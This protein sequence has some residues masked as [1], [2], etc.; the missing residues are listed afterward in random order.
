MKED[1]DQPVGRPVDAQQSAGEP[2]GDPRWTPTPNEEPANGPGAVAALVLILAAVGILFVVR[3]GA[4][5]PIAFIVAIIGMVM[6]HEWGHFFTARRAGMKATE[7]F[8]GFGPRIWSFR[9]GETEYGVKAV[10]IGGYVR[11]IGM[12]NLEQ[13]DPAEEDR[14]FRSKRFGARFTV[15]VAGVTMNLICAFVL[16][17]IAFAATGRLGDTTTTVSTVGRDTPAEAAGI[18]AG[19]RIVSVNG[20]PLDEW[21]DIGVALTGTIDEQIPLVVERDGAMRELTATPVA[22]GDDSDVG[23]LGVSPESETLDMSPGEAVGETAS[24]MW[25]APVEVGKEIGSFMSPSRLSEEFGAI[26][27]D[28]QR[29]GACVSGIPNRPMGILGMT[30]ASGDIAGGSLWNFVF[31]LAL[32]N[33]I[34]AVF[35][36]IPL[37]PFD[38]GHAAIAI[39]ETINGKITGRPNYRS[40][41]RKMIPVSAF[42]LILLI[43]LFV[44]VTIL[45]I[46]YAFF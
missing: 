39:Y 22:R 13:V 31:L 26:G 36:L 1:L 32:I 21:S 27:D 19:D 5:I 46:E 7:F 30:A 2:E 18:E 43:L 16:F 23:C 3:P 9:R 8:V 40:D 35:N 12:N 44:T 24:I 29:G 45:D 28:E 33:L 41:Y 37:L 25:R 4:R 38:G 11:I 17:T 34:L 15:L 20:Q 6:I 42:V 10:L 14:T